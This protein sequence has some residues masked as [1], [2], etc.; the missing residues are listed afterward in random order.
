MQRYGIACNLSSN[1]SDTSKPIWYIMRNYPTDKP[2]FC[3]STTL[4]TYS[5]IEDLIAQ[6]NKSYLG[7]KIKECKTDLFY[8]LLILK[9]FQETYHP[10]YEISYDKVRNMVKKNEI[11]DVLQIISKTYH[12]IVS[13]N[14]IE[15]TK[16]E[17]VYN[18]LTSNLKYYM[19]KNSLDFY[20]YD[21]IYNAPVE[22][23]QIR[24]D[25]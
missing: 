13:F 11:Y 15:A 19:E 20:V 10:L 5:R 18:R 23:I 7:N 25:D 6:I 4:M 22:L 3:T 24:K 21:L 9:G 14:N 12:E 2:R 1:T 17:F 8:L 16:N